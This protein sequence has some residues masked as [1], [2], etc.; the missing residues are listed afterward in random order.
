M[1][2]AD[3][4]GSR[5]R[6]ASAGGGLGAIPT[7]GGVRFRL[8]SAH[9]DRVVLCLFDAPDDATPARRVDL[10]RRS[11]DVWETE[12]G[13][14]PGQLYGYR[15]SGPYEPKVGH[16]FN[17]S[18][19]LVD[20]WARAITGEPAP[21]AS[22]FGFVPM[23]WPSPLW[24]QH[25]TDLSYSGHDSAGAMPKC[26]VVD[27]AFDWRGD[28]PPRTPWGETVIYE[29]HVKGMTRRH[30]QVEQR[31]RGTY[32]GLA[33]P[34]VIEHL[35]ALGVTA[36]E[37]LPVHQIAREAHLMVKD[38]PNYWGYST[39]GY[40]APHAGYATGGRGEQVAEFKEMV[41][42]L[43]SAGLEVILD[44]VYNHTCEGGRMG[45]TL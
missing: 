18:K 38:L 25:S 12:L 7:G 24:R 44:V 8:C 34:P 22:I 39:L 37:L 9:A 33:A 30:P 45:P 1:R 6:P 28:E 23:G 31:L 13:T 43:H 4:D 11:G 41:R 15:V 2:P 17:P 35:L 3:P 10:E 40:F 16:R 21:D 32:L 36:V 14:A 5:R 20:P 19:L 29:C 26:V 42:R 27:P